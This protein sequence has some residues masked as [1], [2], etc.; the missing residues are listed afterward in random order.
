MTA[1][2]FDLDPRTAA[3]IAD[4]SETYWPCWDDEAAGT[5]AEPK[6]CRFDG[7]EFITLIRA[8]F[9]VSSAVDT[10]LDAVD[11]DGMLTALGITSGTDPGTFGSSW[12]EAEALSDALTLLGINSSTGI[13]EQTGATTFTKRAIGTSANNLVALNG[14][15]QLPAI[16]GS[17]LTNLPTGD[18][19]EI[20]TLTGTSSGATH[21][22]TFTGST[23]ADNE[24]IKVALQSLETAVEGKQASDATLTA[25][26]GLNS[27]A[28]LVEQTGSDAFTKRLIGVANSTDV[29]TRSDADS[30]YA[31]TGSTQM[32]TFANTTVTVFT[33]TDGASVDISPANGEIQLW[34]LG[35]NRT[36]VSPTAFSA[37]QYV[38]L[39]IDDGTA[40]TITWTSVAVTWLPDGTP[41]TLRTSGYTLVVLWK[42]GSTIYGVWR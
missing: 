21:L 20:R 14:S 5:I 4:F 16:D 2:I 9:P 25:L 30:R 40:Y 34:T 28:G 33:I 29:P 37:G 6:T 18:T 38:T 10:F 13:L 17:L 41:P 1:N 15:A 22:G 42:A 36:P 19:D 8:N 32:P 35:A 26:A 23:I 3:D 12:L 27:T 11:Q 24:T 7:D 31:R 39:M